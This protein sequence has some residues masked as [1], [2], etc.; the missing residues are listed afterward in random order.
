[1]NFMQ[2]HFP[3]LTLA[4]VYSTT[5][6]RYTKVCYGRDKEDGRRY[7]WYP[8]SRKQMFI[9]PEPQRAEGLQKRIERTVTFTM[10][11]RSEDQ[12][13]ARQDSNL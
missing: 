6:H 9:D 4:K 7:Q 5:P 12:W 11:P 13:W 3:I 2:G 10:R 1:M 8:R